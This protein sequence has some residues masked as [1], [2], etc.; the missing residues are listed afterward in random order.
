MRLSILLLAFLPAFGQQFCETLLVNKGT[1]ICSFEEDRSPAM[2]ELIRHGAGYVQSPVQTLEVRRINVTVELNECI[3]LTA[4]NDKTGILNRIG[5]YDPILRCSVVN[6]D[7]TVYLRAEAFIP[8]ASYRGEAVSPIRKE[9]KWV[10]DPKTGYL[11][12]RQ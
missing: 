4:K 10:A 6:S 12:W 9:G 7:R 5:E 8:S 11:N 2:P 1:F 3:L